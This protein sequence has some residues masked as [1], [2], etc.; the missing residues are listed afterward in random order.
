MDALDV[1][2]KSKGKGFRPGFVERYAEARGEGRMQKIAKELTTLH[3]QTPLAEWQR[4]RITEIR[5][6]GEFHI[7]KMYHKARVLEMQLMEEYAQHEIDFIMASNQFKRD[8]PGQEWAPDLTSK[9]GLVARSFWKRFMAT[10]QKLG[11][12]YGTNTQGN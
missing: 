11:I 7:K 2:K 12:N 4:N 1:F 3:A 10:G 6:A 5:N 9:L 8:N